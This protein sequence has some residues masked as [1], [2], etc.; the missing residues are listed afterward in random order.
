MGVVAI[1]D[2]GFAWYP[3]G[4]KQGPPSPIVASAPDSGEDPVGILAS[5]THA[6]GT[7]S[8]RS[9]NFMSRTLSLAVGSRYQCRLG[10]GLAVG[11]AIYF[12]LAVDHHA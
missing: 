12:D 5:D 11:N 9:E 10:G 2:H 3:A 6:R 1:I 4:N 7:Y 8:S